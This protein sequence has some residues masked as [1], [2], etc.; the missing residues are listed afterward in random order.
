MP[1][2]SSLYVHNYDWKD[3]QSVRNGSPAFAS[4]AQGIAKNQHWLALTD[5]PIVNCMNGAFTSAYD[6]YPITV[7]VPPFCNFVE[8]AF[9]CVG[10]STRT[11]SAA[12]IATGENTSVINEVPG[13]STTLSR[14]RAGW[15]FMNAPDD[16]SDNS[17]CVIK[18][19]S[20]PSENWTQAT[21]DIE[22]GVNV[23]IYI[24]HYRV[25]PAAFYSVA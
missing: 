3:P 2:V 5:T 22:L 19:A 21:V 14:E 7:D 6:P 25:I 18:L 9:F 12:I 17:P 4:Y 23:T 8:F 1:Y 11:D 16:G 10:S 24:A 13:S 20:A 15:V